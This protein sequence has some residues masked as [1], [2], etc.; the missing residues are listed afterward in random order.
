M[1][2]E[3]NTLISSII[4]QIISKE[5]VTEEYVVKLVEWACMMTP[6]TEKEKNEVI[7][8]LYSRLSIKMDRGNYIKDTDHVPW[9]YNA[10][11]DIDGKFWSRYRDY[12]ICHQNF[13]PDVVRTLESSTDDMMD[14]LGNPNQ[15]NGFSRRGLVI[16]DVQSGKTATYTG[17]INKAADSGYRIIIL[18]TGTI[19][20][21]RQQTQC[22]LDEG[23]VGLSSKDQ[24]DCNRNSNIGVGDIDPSISAWVF[25]STTSDF[26]KR[27]AD[28]VRGRLNDINSPIL[29][30]LKKNKSV[31][32]KLE[33]WFKSNT[34]LRE[35]L[36]MLLVDDEADNASVNTKKAEDDPTA[37]NK[38]I[39]KLLKLFVK[40]S[41]VGFTATPFANIFINPD[42][43]DEMLEDDLFPRDFI[44]SL[45]SPTN[46]VGAR[47]IYSEDGT[48]NYMLKN[49]SD[50][51]RF[52]PLKHKKYF[53]VQTIPDSMEE[54]IG[55]FLITNAIR[56][57]RG[58]INNH[59]SMLINVSIYIDVQKKIEHIVE[60]YV[61]D[62]QREVKNYQ[63]LGDEALKYSSF[64]FLKRVYFEHFDPLKRKEFEGEDMSFSWEQIQKQLADSIAPI[65]VRAVNGGNASKNLNYDEYKKDGLRIIAIGGYS[66]SR[67]LTLEGLCTSYFY[68][69]SKMYD[70]L[71][72]M[73]RWFGYRPNYESLCQV[74]LTKEASDWYEYISDAS[75]EL[76]DQVKKMRDAN[77]TPKDFGLAVR[78]DISSLMVTA[79]N[80]MRTAQNYSQTI[81]LS[82]KMVE[83]PYLYANK[84]NQE[85]NLENTKS[86][87]MDLEQDG[88]KYVNNENYAIKKHQILNVPKE[89]VVE[90]LQN[91]DSHYYNMNFSIESL[92]DLVKEDDSLLNLWDIAIASGE[93]KQIDFANIKGLPMVERS[94]EFK[95]SVGIQISG[96]KSRLGS[97]T[98]AKTGLTKEIAKEIESK[99]EKKTFSQDDYFNSGEKRNPILVIYPLSLKTK[100]KD[101]NGNII[102]DEKKH[103]F[104]EKISHPL[105]GLSI[106]IPKVDGQK[107]T[108]CQYKINMRRYKELVGI[109]DNDDYQE[110]DETIE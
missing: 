18:L 67:G 9:Y 37:I 13:S 52:I 36:P 32:E 20:K 55:S 14:L 58:E 59:R 62:I 88:Y 28:Q 71:M 86:W 44:Y 98:F 83:T 74:W 97:V 2:N 95:E 73:G 64:Q 99:I 50:C 68:R 21:L 47:T 43:D 87:L 41:Y 16:G 34:D 22:R 24:M 82:G 78:S 54:A 65:V 3:Q 92:I 25:T 27:I 35:Q 60:N 1:T 91:F 72:Q 104:V 17:L 109:S 70:T 108:K 105:I 101:V 84:K 100:S 75:D 5:N 30:V 56:D 6:L 80:K 110:I 69:N 10:K 57:L 40:S 61:R 33:Q 7:K 42:T 102:D 38:C 90:Y 31:L 26:N 66:L 63:M 4:P 45:E 51:E 77:L 81:S 89:Y 79:M 103:A 8:E 106:G 53:D 39:R 93:G 11:K 76:R 29:F 96:S 107:T 49:H 15:N 94:F 48:H 85:K 46:Y 23:F 12:L 19:E